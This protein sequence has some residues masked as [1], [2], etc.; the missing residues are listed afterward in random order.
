[1][2]FLALIFGVALSPLAASGQTKRQNYLDQKY[3]LS[4]HQKKISSVIRA[5]IANARPHSAMSYLQ[6]GERVHVVVEVE[7][8]DVDLLEVLAAYGRIE[9]FN[10]KFG[11][12]QSWLEL[13]KVEEIAAYAAVRK[14]K[15]VRRGFHRAGSRVS[16]GD[17]LL[18]ADDVREVLGVDGSGIKV[19][20]ISDGVDH[21]SKAYLSG[22]LPPE[23]EI[24]DNTAW[25]DEGTAMLEIIHDLAPGASLAFSQ[26]WGSRLEFV[27]S[28]E[29]LVEAGADV[30][31]DDIGFLDSPF[32]TD[33]LMAREAENAVEKGVVFVSAAGNSAL[34]HYEGP[35][36]P[37]KVTSPQLL[38]HGIN[39]DIVHDFGGGDFTQRV[40]V[41]PGSEVSVYLQWNEVYGVARDDYDLLIF[42]A[43][44]DCEARGQCE[45]FW[46]SDVQ[47]G[48]DDPFENALISN[49]TNRD[50]HFDRVVQRFSGSR[51]RTIEMYYSGALV[52]EYN[53][54]AG[55]VWGQ[56]AASQVIAVG[57]ISAY[58]SGSDDISNYSSHGPAVIYFP[59]FESRPKPD[60][61][62]IDGVRVTGAG[63]FDSPF[64]GTSA[65]AP[66][67]A[68]IAAL[69]LQ[70]DPLLT[71]QQVRQVLE[72]TAV[73]L[74][75]T[76]IYGA[77][78]VD[79]FAA[80]SAV[81]EDDFVYELSPGWSMVSVPMEGLDL[82]LNSLFP[83]A[84]S[85]FAFADGYQP[86]TEL[87]PCQGYWLNLENGG[88]YQL[89][90]KGVDECSPALPAGWSIVGVPWGGA[91]Q[92]QIGQDPAAILVS[93]F[94]F[95]GGYQT[96]QQMAA[97]AGYWVS[98]NAAG[99]LELGPVSAAR[100]AASVPG[101]AALADGVLWAAS[102]GRRQEVYLGTDPGA[103]VELPPLPPTAVLDLRL[104]VQG[105]GV[106]QV[107]KRADSAA[108]RVQLQ[109]GEVELGW[110][111]NPPAARSWELVVDGRSQILQGRGSVQVEGT[112]T[113]I[114]VRQGYVRAVP[115]AYFLAQNFPNPFNPTTTIHYD[116]KEA[117][118]IALRI[119]NVMGQQVRELVRQVQ[120]AGTYSVVW[121]GRDRHGQ[122]MANGVYFY[123]LRAGAFRSMRR[124]VLMQ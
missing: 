1:M 61:S 79:A 38:E 93:V 20:V 24:L 35:F 29:K 32:F 75:G 45:I 77:G 109:G 55:S 102:R 71:P 48:N 15:P 56:P 2:L 26:G 121:D 54:S 73:E 89:L 92:A 22:D 49:F 99:S 17:I 67:V 11:L 100:I 19:G 65:A 9:I 104:E 50:L 72:D 106:G 14:I 34:E 52:D 6:S 115:Q 28:V 94:G 70:Q 37:I 8:P 58:D 85:A 13:V 46:G 111:M 51:K 78:R 39:A 88:R 21:I 82:A 118:Q 36:V 91:T 74:G 95:S 76:N 5:T 123:E 124:M 98:L 59:S 57:A 116:L 103:V 83:D 105:V 64:F 120:P 107:P 84:I 10:E 122:E 114:Q 16:Q 18:N 90:G 69:V 44:G 117:G 41:E 87:V 113:Q 81:V 43:D 110:E 25:G 119:Y 80:V 108:Y 60:I 7:A 62:A 96:V 33:G 27:R 4:P 47:D 31:V 40:I 97:G 3:N 66:H 42:D 63:G 12:I 30:I 53:I 23:I 112:A 101:K 68:A 86:V